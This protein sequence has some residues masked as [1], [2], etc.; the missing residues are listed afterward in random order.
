M[1]KRS[2]STRPHRGHYRLDGPVGSIFPVD[3]SNSRQP[4]RAGRARGCPRKV[5]GGR[6]R[7]F[8]RPG[9]RSL[10]CILR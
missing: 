4:L 2:D 5:A 8:A 1:Q 7:R 3:A 10:R 6:R 9:L